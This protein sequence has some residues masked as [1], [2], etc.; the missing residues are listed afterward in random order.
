MY[1]RRIVN[2]V[3]PPATSTAGTNNPA[4]FPL[5]YNGFW[6]PPDMSEDVHMLWS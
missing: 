4:G 2:G 3:A 1:A 5:S 6:Q